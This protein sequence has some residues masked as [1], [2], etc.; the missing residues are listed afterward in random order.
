[1]CSILKQCWNVGYV[2]LLTFSFII[3]KIISIAPG[4]TVVMSF[5]KKM[6]DKQFYVVDSKDLVKIKTTWY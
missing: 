3:K 6:S 5:V 2:T 1:M 4:E